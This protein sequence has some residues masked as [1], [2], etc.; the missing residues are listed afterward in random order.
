MEFKILGSLEVAENGR[1]L[2]LTGQ[3]QRA[4]NQIGPPTRAPK[5]IEVRAHDRCARASHP[6]VTFCTRV[7][8]SA[9]AT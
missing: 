7:S 8:K 6:G 3:K 4:L 5:T 1:R 2:S 9:T